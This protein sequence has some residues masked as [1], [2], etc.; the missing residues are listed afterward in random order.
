MIGDKA[1]KKC[2]SLTEVVIPASVKSVG[3]EAFAECPCE[4][5]LK[6]KYP[7]LFS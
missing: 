5:E 6:K 4:P 3:S 7:K 2:T 1:F